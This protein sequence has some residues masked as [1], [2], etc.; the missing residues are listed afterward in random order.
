MHCHRQTRSSERN[1]AIHDLERVLPL[2]VIQRDPIPRP[3]E[4]DRSF[5]AVPQSSRVLLGLRASG[6]VC[7]HDCAR[8]IEVRGIHRPNTKLPGP[9][10]GSAILFGSIVVEY[11]PLGRSKYSSTMLFSLSPAKCALTPRGRTGACTRSVM[12]RS[13]C[14][15]FGKYHSNHACPFASRVK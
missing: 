8:G 10:D 4:A 15:S 3:V 7:A 1:E 14:R 11:R 6:V 9:P 5:G 12:R 13:K 2:K